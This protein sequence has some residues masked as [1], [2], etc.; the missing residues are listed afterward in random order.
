MRKR[1]EREWGFGYVNWLNVNEAGVL[2]RT[3][4]NLLVW[5][6]FLIGDLIF[7]TEWVRTLDGLSG[8]VRHCWMRVSE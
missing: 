4:G 2:L 3:C 8:A 7:R 1:S 6:V 5:R